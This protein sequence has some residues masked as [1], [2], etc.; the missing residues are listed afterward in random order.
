MP[1]R[2]ATHSGSPRRRRARCASAALATITTLLTSALAT[3]TTTPADATAPPEDSLRARYHLTGPPGWLSDPQRPVWAGGRYHLYYLFSDAP[4]TG[5]GDWHHATTTDNVVFTDQGTAIPKGP[6]FPVWTGS[7]V[8]DTGNTAG[9][10][11]GA[12]VALATQPT[13]GDRYDQEQYLWYS[14][15]DGHTFTPYGAPVIDNP[16]PG[17]EDWFRDPKIEWDPARDEWVAAIGRNQFMSFYTSPDL[18]HWTF[19]SDFEYRTPDIGGME[20]PDLFRIRADDGTVRWV[21]AASTQ[22]D[23]SGLPDTYGYWTGEWNGTAFVPDH[24]DPKWLDWGWDWYAA[25]SWPDHTQPLDRRYAVGWMN[26]WRYASLS[27][28]PT[29]A[30]DGTSGQMSLVRSIRLAKR[31]PGAGDYHLL[32]EPVPGLADHVAETRAL[33]DRIVNGQVELDYRGTA[34]ELE[35]DVSWTQLENVGVT[36]GVPPDRSRGTNIGVWQGDRLYVDRSG[37]DRPGEAPDLSFGPYQQSE[38]PFG[39]DATSVHLRIFVDRTSVEVFADEGKVVH[40]SLVHFRRGD[41]GIRL[42]A[43]GGAAQFTN[44]RIRECDDVTAATSRPAPYAGFEGTG[45]DGWSTTGAAF[46]TGPAAGTLP[47]QQPVTGFSGQRLANSYHGGD[48][49]TGLLK[50]PDFTVTEPFVNFLMGGGHNPAPAELVNDFEGSDWGPGWS[51]TGSFAGQGP[52]ASSLPNQS[53]AQVLD[54]FVNGGDSSTGSVWSPEFTITRDQVDLLVA[55]GNH[56]W[57]EP[58]TTSVN[59][60]VDG[61]VRRTATGRN[62]DVLRRVTWD[63]H[64]L[65]G[66]R[67][68]IEVV[69]DNTGGWGHLM[70]D[71]VVFTD[72]ATLGLGDPDAQTTVN[73]VVDGKVVR[74]ATGQDEERLRWALWNVA[75]LEGRTAHLEVIDRATGGWGHVTADEI[76][77]DDRPAS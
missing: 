68:R 69:D 63:V 37:S 35:A 60:L 27:H 50:S 76:S 36:V 64:Q 41:D 47:D 28:T 70:V 6:D 49:A 74:T 31:G 30:T 1:T 22:G 59:L 2:P 57:G 43:S 77:F 52:T 39:P 3:L 71:R 51:G 55:G 25:V 45:W 4:D 53:G 48:A 32:S 23:R 18:K 38:S 9:F 13:G 20:C 29:Y 72:D 42:Y 14:T 7:A 56:R 33:P 11:A 40:S 61:E 62:D 73:L 34:Y 10:G 44:M 46:G 8:V 15:D 24:P 75:D 54:T 12:V 58:A 16:D 19:R 17:N 21:L 26:N 66:K 67:A 5:Q 65:V